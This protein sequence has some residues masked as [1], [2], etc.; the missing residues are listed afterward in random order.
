MDFSGKVALITGASAGIG[1]ATSLQFAS[2]GAK[3]VVVDMNKDGLVSLEKEILEYTS[4]VMSIAMD[5]SDEEAVYN[6]IDAVKQ[7]FGG[8]DIL[9]NNAGI[10]RDFETFIDSSSDKWRK[11]IDV[12]ILGVMY[13][14]KAVLPSMIDKGYG[15][16]INLGSV[17]GVYGKAHMCC[18]SM[19]KGAVISFTKALAKEVT[20]KGITVNCVSPGSVSDSQV[21]TDYNNTYSTE[22]SFAG[23]TGSHMENA[24]LICFIASDEA[25]YISGQNIQ[26]D[27]CRKS[28]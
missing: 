1:R 27:G 22:L 4:D 6:A 9:V 12:N 11:Y 18:Y 3:V 5:V 26:I 16:I 2:H 24:N 23:R 28:M 21:D 7:R 15:R 13:F 17:A 14:A 20:A 25:A 8:I 10:F 19:T